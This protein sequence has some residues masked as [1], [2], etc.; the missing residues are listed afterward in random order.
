MLLELIH[1][2]GSLNELV[3]GIISGLNQDHIEEIENI[4]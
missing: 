2:H 1:P 3:Y 4:P